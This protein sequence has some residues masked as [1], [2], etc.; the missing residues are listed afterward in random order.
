MS[1]SV[2]ESA[3]V[4]GGSRTISLSSMFSVT[5]GSS[6]PA[7]LV[8]TGLDRN[9][10]PQG[11]SGATGTLSGN[12]HTDSFASIG[13]DARSVGLVFTYQTAT[14]RYYNSTYGYLDQITYTS[15]GSLDDVTNLSL[16]GTSNA[17]LATGYATNPY[18]L[19][20]ADAKGYLGSVTIATQP[21]FSG[22]VPA[23]ATPNSIAQAA[24]S[25]VGKAWN[26]Y[27][28][29]TLASTIAAQAGTSLPLDSTAPGVTGNA[30][31]EWIV[32]FD[33]SKQSGN[34]Q[35]MVKAGEIIV[36]SDGTSGHITTCVSGSGSTAMLV[37]NITYVNGAGTVLN[38]AKDGSATDVIVQAAHL[39][40]QEWTGVL[41]SDV[42]IYELDTPV[43]STLVTGASLAFN[44]KQTLSTLFSAA[45]PAGNAITQ[46]QIY[47]TAASDSLTVNGSA[48][49]AHTAA[50]AATATSLSSVCV[51][52]GSTACT[53][54]IEVRAFNGSY[55]GD[56]QTINLSVTGATAGSGTTTTPTA[57]TPATSYSAITVHQTANQI[58]TAGSPLSFTLPAN[59]F[60][61]TGGQIT[62][63]KAYQTSGPSVVS[64]LHYNAASETFSGSVPTTATGT[65]TIEVAAQDNHAQTAY[66]TFS[67]TFANNSVLAK[68]VGIS[69]LHGVTGMEV[70][71]LG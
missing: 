56:W 45:D 34:W 43:V 41:T 69:S 9:E 2:T 66:D 48:V 16:Y 33:G 38:A 59:S 6:D 17:N 54:T 57:T 8:L 30:N 15:S 3:F 67:V 40:S 13:G 20:Q 68:L 23:Q 12:G 60:S 70:V 44:A 26:M 22:T 11:S 63:T 5:A 51:V 24:Q 37:D 19:M 32:A 53:D 46:Y 28:C 52:S 25:F 39:A 47:D 49:T 27:G 10:Y 61:E 29:W 65:I 55:W 18:S 42:K 1:I 50:G 58:W 14:G 35:S 7:Y 31:G 21:G 62:T 36:I 4:A 64:W 71:Q